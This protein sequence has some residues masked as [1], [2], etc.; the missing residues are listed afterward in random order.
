[1]RRL[2]GAHLVLLLAFLSVSLSAKADRGT[3]PGGYTWKDCRE[4]D[5]PPCDYVI[6][7]ASDAF[8]GLCSDEVFDDPFDALGF[9]FRFY[10]VDYTDYAISANGVVYFTGAPACCDD[11][12]AALTGMEGRSFA[13]VLWDDWAMDNLD[14][15]LLICT[16]LPACSN[17]GPLTMIESF[18]RGSGVDAGVPYKDFEWFSTAHHRPTCT[19]DFGEQATF[20]MRIY[21][22]GRIL[23]QYLDTSVALAAVDD[24][25]S[26]TIGV[27]SGFGGDYTEVSSDRASIPFTPYSIL[28]TPPCPELRC[29]GITVDPAPACE[30]ETVTLTAEISGGVEPVTVEWDLD[31]DTFVEETGNPIMADLPVGMNRVNVTVT[32]SCEEPGPQ[33]CTEPVFV[34]VEANPVPMV[35]PLGPTSF[36]AMSGETVTLDAG[37]AFDT[38]QWQ[39]DGID[40]AGSD[41]SMLI[42]SSSGSYRVVVTNAAGCEGVSDPV[43]ID[44]ES[45]DPDCA[46]LVCDGIIVTPEEACEGVEQTFRLQT[47]GGEGSVSVTWDFDG[48]TLTDATGTSVVMTLPVG[49]TSVI[50]TAIDSCMFPMEGT[51]LDTASARVVPGADSLPEVSGMGEEPLLVVPD[52]AT[53]TIGEVPEATAYNV[54]ADLIGSWYAPATLRGSS[55]TITAWDDLAGGVIGLAYD[56]PPNTWFVVTASNSCGEG[57]A[58]TDST[59]T[60]RQGVGTWEDCGAGP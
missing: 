23:Y 11:T 17:T 34:T 45:C 24:G 52:P 12:N 42:V 19:E 57:P 27:S 20:G 21:A 43:V 44:A 14:A 35:M 46:P 36:C 13:A 22:D 48:D 60:E 37:G 31:G 9:T 40:L 7:A 25:A 2:R 10:G 49:V 58:G 6:N 54:Q 47:T 53:V 59:G 28:I 15:L 38:Y 50:A 1:M 3:G 16:T 51:C 56:P 39:L 8:T 41:G 18:R 26:A 29:D 30:D 55:C 32:D 5:G 33:S 4:P